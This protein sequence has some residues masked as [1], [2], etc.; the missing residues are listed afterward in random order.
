MKEILQKQQ[1]QVATPATLQPPRPSHPLQQTTSPSA[2]L[3]NNV[4]PQP[5]LPAAASPAS[6]PPPVSQAAPII[7]MAISSSGAVPAAAGSPS[8]QPIT[9]PLLNQQQLQK[10][11]PEQR[12]AYVQQLQKL[13]QKGTIKLPPQIQQAL[14]NAMPQGVSPQATGVVVTPSSSAIGTGKLP[15]LQAGQVQV[16]AGTIASLQAAMEKQKLLAK[17]QQQASIVISAKLPQPALKPLA[18]A[19]Q[20]STSLANSSSPSPKT[21]FADM[22]LAKLGPV[23][24]IL[25]QA[26]PPTPAGKKSKGKTKGAD[27]KQEAVE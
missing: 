9:I 16:Q 20:Q 27:D 6:T 24:A 25:P 3:S 14:F 13:Q 11:T 12:V 8:P 7:P 18:A 21:S 4:S 26:A 15:I 22:K 1:Q 10:L 23:G 19:G 2:P 17:E 5:G